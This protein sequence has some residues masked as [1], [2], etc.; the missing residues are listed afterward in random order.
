MKKAFSFQGGQGTGGYVAVY[1]GTD[2][3]HYE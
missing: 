2:P 1:H 3:F